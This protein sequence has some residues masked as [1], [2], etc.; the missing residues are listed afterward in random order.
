MTPQDSH[1]YPKYYSVIDDHSHS[2]TPMGGGA[3]RADSSANQILMMNM[4]SIDSNSE[5]ANGSS[6]ISQTLNNKKNRKLKRAGGQQTSQAPPSDTNVAF[7]DEQ[8]VQSQ[9]FYNEA[10]GGGNSQADTSIT[11]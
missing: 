8:F 5:F 6:S 2:I 1:S 11:G 4:A 3:T 9:S 10:N 7:L